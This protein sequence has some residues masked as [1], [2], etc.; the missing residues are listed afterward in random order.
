VFLFIYL[1][2]NCEE[3]VDVEIYRD[4]VDLVNWWDLSYLESNSP[5]WS[6]YLSTIRL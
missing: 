4:I 6:Q 3:L 5:K 2:F 1:F